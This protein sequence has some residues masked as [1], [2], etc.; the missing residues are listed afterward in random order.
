M[1]KKTIFYLSFIF[2]SS[3]AFSQ[4]ALFP[5]NGTLYDGNLH[6][7]QLLINTD[8]LTALLA[9]V[10]RWTNHSYPASLVYDGVD[11]IKNVGVRIKGNSSRNAKKL[12]FKISTDEYVNQSYQ[13]LKTFNLNGEHNDPSVVREYMACYVMG[14]AGN[15][16][17]RG[18]MVK[19]YFNNV[20]YGIYGNIEH[21]NK[22][23]AE[24]HLG[25]N[26]GNLYKCSWPAEL[27]W[28]GEDQNTYKAI[29]NQS[30]LNERAYD[31][32]TN[33][34]ADDYSD[35]VN[36]IR[37]IN[38]TPTD[39][40][41]IKIEQVFEVHQFL[42]TLATEILIGHWDNYFMNKNNYFLYHNISTGKFTYIPY[43]MDNTFGIQWGISNIDTRDINN[44]GNTQMSTS[45]LV[46][47]ILGL[48]E[49]KN[50]FNKQIRN[51]CDS[52]FNGDL[53][54]EID[55]I[56]TK[57]DDA[58]KTDSFYVQNWESD[59]GYTYADWLISFNGSLPNHANKGVNPY[60]TNRY[61]SAKSQITITNISKQESFV[62]S[63]FPNPTSEF[64]TIF[65]PFD[66]L[67]FIKIYNSQIQE[68]VIINNNHNT[69]TKI[70]VHHFPDGVYLIELQLKNGE[71]SRNKLVIA[72]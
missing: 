48:P 18:N 14:M 61:L 64:I 22:K 4:S 59:Y 19:L 60:I 58:V 44:W 69:S 35:L 16:A 46:T 34:T 2:L 39:S 23:F 40:F 27:T 66:D 47:R 31:L 1:I 45:P 32:K 53:F 51:L 65:Y 38:Q 56:K 70:D 72:R 28:M 43:D 41:K 71:I 11:T 21:V 10:N 3:T 63:L 49:Y 7:I 67:R 12:S 37:V 42:R 62:F 6:T 20:Y 5:S 55:A 57:I 26:Q 24:T 25:D 30:P 29:I 17:N 13:G 50:Y 54:S 15:P 8:S 9:P 33:E 52:V 68:M 36:L